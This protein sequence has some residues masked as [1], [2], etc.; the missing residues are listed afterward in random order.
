MPEWCF[1]PGEGCPDGVGSPDLAI[2][3]NVEDCQEGEGEQ[4]EEDQVQ[5]VYVHLHIKKTVNEL[6]K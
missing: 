5:P 4:V 2:D 3:E 6:L 1:I